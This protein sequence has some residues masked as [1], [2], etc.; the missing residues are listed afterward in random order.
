M[1]GRNESAVYFKLQVD[2]TD[3]RQYIHKRNRENLEQVKETGKVT[4]FHAILTAMTKAAIERPQ[5][6]RFIIGRRVYQRND[7]T[8]A[9]VIKSE[10]RDDAN[11]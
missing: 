6:N 7:L 3:L 9:F 5:V 8:C 11:E 1:K 4:L 2:I 10:F